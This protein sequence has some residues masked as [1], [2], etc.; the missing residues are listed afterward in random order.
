VVE[1]LVNSSNLRKHH[2]G[3]VHYDSPDE[4]GIDVA[5]LY[6]KQ[7]FELLEIIFLIF[8]YSINFLEGKMGP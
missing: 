7:V 2:Y 8:S 4:R 3:F 5:L 1:D 6:N